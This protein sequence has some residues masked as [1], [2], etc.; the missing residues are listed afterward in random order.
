MNYCSEKKIY[1]E[2]SNLKKTKYRKSKYILIYTIVFLLLAVGVFISYISAGKSFIW[3]G[4]NS[5]ANAMSAPA[6]GFVQH[7][8]SLVYYGQ[9]L[10]NI[11]K[12]IFID[13]SY[14][15]LLCCR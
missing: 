7:Y 9:Y 1:T 10:C 6:D 3:I 4:A 15:A 11:L 2:W 13:H 8:N 14:I 12:T 5:A